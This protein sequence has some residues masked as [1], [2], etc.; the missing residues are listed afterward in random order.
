M[1]TL[2]TGIALIRTGR[3]EA[4][5]PSLA[6]RVPEAPRYLA[7]LMAAKASGEHRALAAVPDAPPRDVIEAD[8]ALVVRTRL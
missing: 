7:G 3:M 6:A 1:R 8:I 5:L 4:H 2:L